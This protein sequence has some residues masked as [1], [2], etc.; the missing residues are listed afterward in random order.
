M[1]DVVA[2]VLDGMAAEGRE[3]RGFLY[4]GLML[5]A[6]GPQVVEFNVRLG[7]PEA[8]VVLPLVESS[9]ID[10]M[11]AAASGTLDGRQCVLKR[12]VYVGVVVAS[13]GYPGAYETGKVV[14]GLDAVERMTDVLVFHA[15]TRVREG[16]VITGGGRVLTVVARG[17]DYPH[18]IARAYAAVDLIDFDGK[19][20]RRDIGRKAL[21]ATGREGSLG[22]PA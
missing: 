3:Y 21:I 4:C 12:D 15:G 14:E 18:A 22:S 6:N 19:H 11:Q 13:G 9:L 8:Q 1:R 7:D 20:A 17:D 5:T 10:L 2:P 16:R